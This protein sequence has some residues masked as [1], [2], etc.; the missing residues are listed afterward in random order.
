MV[1]RDKVKREFASYVSNY[2]ANDPKI[3]LK[4]VHTYKV[5]ELCEIIARSVELTE[6]EVDLAWLIGMLHDIGR[7]EQCRIYNTFIDADSVNHAEFGCE[8]LFGKEELIKRYSSDD[9][10]YSYIHDAIFNH[11]AFRIADDLDDK[12]RMF[13]NI[14]RDADKI[15]I[16]R[17]NNET[18]LTDIYNT[19]EE[20]L[21]SCSITDEV[22]N[23]F[24]EHHCVLRKYKKT[25]VDNVVGHISMMFELVYKKSK[26]LAR[27]LGYI[28]KMLEF[29]SNNPDTN[30]KFQIMKNEMKKFF[31]NI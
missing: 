8:L 13:A 6:D 12:T 31:S 10:I 30:D 27:D 28:D 9:T 19:T 26:E 21:Y 2:N 20:E 22:M 16:I 29:K 1:D 14:L 15:D 4:I 18:S 7:F 11:S 17:A 23:S 25:P 5:S 3:M 24:Y